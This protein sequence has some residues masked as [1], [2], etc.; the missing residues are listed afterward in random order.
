[1]KNPMDKR[2][3]K[4]CIQ[5]KKAMLCFLSE[6]PLHKVTVTDLCRICE[7]NR[8]TF[9]HHF[10]DVFDLLEKMEDDLLKDLK[11]KMEQL[12]KSQASPEMVSQK[13]CEFL[14]ARQTEW[15][16]FLHSEHNRQFYE[17]ID[18]I[19]MPYFE[20]RV[21]QNYQIPADFNENDLR[22]ILQ[23]IAA[24]YYMF[25]LQLLEERTEDKL[26]WKSQ[27]AAKLSDACLSRF[28]TKL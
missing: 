6:K 1:M 21:C 27:T 8:A 22:N 4:T 20:K 18:K 23:F 3:E 10:Q 14:F 11:E 16:I 15:N 9:Y 12:E 5:L 25:F 2:A 7:V 28:F 19:I 24:G 13:L 26:L 17:K